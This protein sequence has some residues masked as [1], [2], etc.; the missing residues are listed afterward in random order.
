M[1]EDRD[2]S[3]Q[4][5]RPAWIVPVIGVVLVAVVA[6]WFWLHKPQPEVADADV[7]PPEAAAVDVEPAQRYPLDGAASAATDAPVPL[8]A[9]EDSDAPL[10]VEF[11][12]LAGTQAVTTWLVPDGVVRRIVATVDNLPRAMVTEKVRALRPVPGSLVV[13]RSPID[14]ETGEDRIVLAPAN[15]ARYDAAVRLLESLDV[16]QVAL[17]YRSYYPLFQ[18]AYEDLG[19]PGRYFNDRVV[20]VIDHLVETPIPDAPPALLQPKAMYEFADVSLEERSAGQKLLIR[21]GPRH[22]ATVKARLTALRGE[23]AGSP[24]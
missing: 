4:D 10:A 7:P 14:V 2:V 13:E 19:Y 5:G 17:L 24:Q 1:S 8:P 15:Y 3:E 9:L 6:G 18:Q 11:A 12:T 21:M 22:A 20:E 23:I 16:R